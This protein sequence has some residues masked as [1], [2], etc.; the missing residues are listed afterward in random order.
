MPSNACTKN[1]IQSTPL[2]ALF[3]P[4]EALFTPYARILKLLYNPQSIPHF[5]C[6]LLLDMDIVC[7]ICQPRLQGEN[8]C[9]SGSERKSAEDLSLKAGCSARERS[10][11]WGGWRGSVGLSSRCLR[12]AVR[13]LRNDCLD[14]G[15]GLNR[16][17]GNGNG[18][19]CFSS[20]CSGFRGGCGSSRGCWCR[21]G[22]R[23][24]AAGCRSWSTDGEGDLVFDAEIVSKGG[25]L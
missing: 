4:L 21:A 2:E 15:A 17:R 8:C 11:G 13:N 1:R 5:P 25:G 23:C 14:S 24:S 3:T 18:G 20:G 10:D 19:G 7:S 6:T 9:E 12:L 16:G 22:S